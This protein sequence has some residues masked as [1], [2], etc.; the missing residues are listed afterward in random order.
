M[1]EPLDQALLAL[2]AIHLVVFVRLSWLRRQPRYLLA[3]TTFLL[4]VAV[5]SL[6]LWAPEWSLAGVA[7]HRWLRWGA[8][9][10][11]AVS[12]G[13]LLYRQPWRSKGRP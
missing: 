9:G 6:R 11:A 8:W 10:S 5:F 1:P 7:L 4:L 13:L 2:F 12:L 3:S